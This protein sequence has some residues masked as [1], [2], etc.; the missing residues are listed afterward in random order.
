MRNTIESLSSLL[1]IQDII[2]TKM[3]NIQCA[4]YTQNNQ[5]T[6]HIKIW[7]NVKLPEIIFIHHM[8]DINNIPDIQV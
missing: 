4:L 5:Y 6:T 7:S 3:N 8:G 1:T 2:V